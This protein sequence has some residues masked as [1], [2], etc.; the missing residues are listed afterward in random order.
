M[1][2]DPFSESTADEDAGSQWPSPI[3]T[4]TLAGGA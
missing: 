4:S 3:R 1:P 2:G